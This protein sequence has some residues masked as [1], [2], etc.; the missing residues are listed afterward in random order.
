VVIILFTAI[1]CINELNGVK[2]N[3]PYVF[4]ANNNG[5]EIGAS[6]KSH[7]NIFF[8]RRVW[9]TDSHTVNV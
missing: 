7:F 3:R 2:T 5:Y 8:F 1:S 4:G 9:W 6:K